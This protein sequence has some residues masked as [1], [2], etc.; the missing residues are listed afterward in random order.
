MTVQFKACTRC[1]GDLQRAGDIYGEYTLC[2][3]CGHTV[4]IEE[5]RTTFKLVRG[6]LKPG[7]PRKSAR[8]RDAA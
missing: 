7:R 3:Q 4:Y 6:R 1:Q 8:R 2:L 5:A